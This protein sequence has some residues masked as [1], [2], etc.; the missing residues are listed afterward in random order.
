MHKHI[1]RNHK[2]QVKLTLSRI[3]TTTL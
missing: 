2:I 1:E 3:Q